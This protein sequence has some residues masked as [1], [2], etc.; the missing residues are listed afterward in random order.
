MSSERSGLEATA[1]RVLQ[2]C[3][4]G[5]PTLGA[6]RLLCIDGPAG[7]GKSTLAAA[8]VAGAR[9]LVPA[10]RLVH[11]DDLYEGWGGLAEVGARV[12][13]RLVA[14]LAAGRPGGYRR[15]DW[16]ADGW[17]EAHRVDPVD[18][19]VLEGVGAG[20]LDY[21]DRITTLVWVEAPARLR[22][23]RGVARDGEHL[24][25]QWEA[26]LA[27]ESVHLVGQRTRERAD[28][29]VDGAGP[30]RLVSAGQC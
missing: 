2:A 11:L 15:W 30:W 8:V 13:D 14:P 3:L 1:A 19:L 29:V 10:V 28:V 25:P 12:R 18:L 23:A 4:T 21:A 5:P 17:A 22:V 24:R 26:W 20:A 16:A 27:A 6:G 9:G 7:A